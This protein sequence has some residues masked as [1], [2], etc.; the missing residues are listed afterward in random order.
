ME[1]KKNKGYSF[2]VKCGGND[3]NSYDSNNEEELG[4]EVTINQCESIHPRT[5]KDCTK[6]TIIS[7]EIKNIQGYNY[8]RCCFYEVGNGVNSCVVLPNDEDFLNNLKENSKIGKKL[9]INLVDCNC[10][11]I[12]KNILNLLIIMLLILC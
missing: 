10:N 1:N 11:F 9:K 4:T 7:S 8:D 3:D 12:K 5:I 2:I 6:H